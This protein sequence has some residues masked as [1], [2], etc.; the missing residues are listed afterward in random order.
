MG[1][2]PPS[3]GRPLLRAWG[4]KQSMKKFVTLRQVGRTLDSLVFIFRRGEI[5][6]VALEMPHRVLISIG[7][8]PGH[9]WAPR[10]QKGPLIG[11]I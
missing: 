8:R 11:V 1:L 3:E 4:R 5:R 9:Q 7:S 2:L 10:L 6:M